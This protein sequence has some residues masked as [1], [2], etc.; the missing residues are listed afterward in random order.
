MKQ[1]KNSAGFTFVEMLLAV[2]ISVMVFA[3]L[4][5]LITKCF[6]L[7]KDATAH[8]QMAQY[9]RIAH[10]RILFGGFANPSGGLLSATNATVSSNSGWSAVSY[11]TVSG[12]GGEKQVKGW[13]G[14]AEQNLLLKQGEQTAYGLSAAYVASNSAPTVKVDSFYA[15]VTND[16]V[17]IEYRLRLSA[18]GKTFTQKQNIQSCLVNI[19]TSYAEEHSEEEDDDHDGDGDHDD[20]DHDGDD[21]HDDHDD[22]GD[23][24]HDHQHHHY[25]HEHHHY[26]D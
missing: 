23:G 15:V 4:G 8:W 17:I 25:H 1:N 21:D 14:E 12:T 5:V 20:D 10:E 22:D 11:G 6:S 3:A 19:Q 24:H 2:S 26:R 18:A 7:W 16:L 13:T 9:S